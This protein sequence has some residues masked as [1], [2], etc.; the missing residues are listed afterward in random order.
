MGLSDTWG[1]NYFCGNILGIN[2]GSMMGI[3]QTNYSGSCNILGRP[4]VVQT[5]SCC[6]HSNVALSYM[7]VSAVSRG[8]GNNVHV[9]LFPMFL[10]CWGQA[11]TLKKQ[12]WRSSKLSGL[13][14]D[15]A[16]VNG[17]SALYIHENL[18]IELVTDAF[19]CYMA[20]VN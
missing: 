5:S 3:S 6:A 10:R 17:L 18:W 8:R 7:L 1:F 2:G 16:H 9:D 11:A 15:S 12:L 13:S 4:G 20:F 19:V 14:L